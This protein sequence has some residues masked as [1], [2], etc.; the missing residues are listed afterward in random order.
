VLG[1]VGASIALLLAMALAGS[2]TSL[3]SWV[4]T[5]LAGSAADL[6]RNHTAGVW[7]A[8]LVAALASAVALAAAVVRLG[9]REL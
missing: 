7:H 5:R 1:A 3:S 8:I 9:R 4:P 6:M 2:I